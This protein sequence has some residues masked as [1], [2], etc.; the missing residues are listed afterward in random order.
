M[1]PLDVAKNFFLVGAWMGIYHSCVDWPFPVS[2][3]CGTVYSFL[4]HPIFWV[5][6]ARTRGCL[7]ERYSASSALSG[8][9]DIGNMEYAANIDIQLYFLAGV[10]IVP[11]WL[12]EAAFNVL[13]LRGG[14]SGASL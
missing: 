4:Y 10:W 8:N 9:G 5:D 7:E 14:S 13:Y 3:E 2:I 12:C 6:H 11:P 1:R